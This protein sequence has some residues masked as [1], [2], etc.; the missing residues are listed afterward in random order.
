MIELT[1]EE[2]DSLIEA[3]SVLNKIKEYRTVSYLDDI[4][5]D[6]YPEWIQH[7]KE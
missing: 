5:N 2:I 4:L 3:R 7:I 6:I 1:F